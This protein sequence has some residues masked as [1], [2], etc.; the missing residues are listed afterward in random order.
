MQQGNQG[1]SALRERE[2]GSLLTVPALFVVGSLVLSVVTVVADELLSTLLPEAILFR[3]DSDSARSILSSIASSAITLTGLVFSV[4]M[5]VLQLTGAQYSPRSMGALLTD[6]NSKYTL[7][8]FVGTFTYSLAV[9][10]TIDP[11]GAEFDRG[12]SVAVA[13]LF[14]LVT[15]AFFIQYVNHVARQIRPASIIGRVAEAAEAAIDAH[16]PD[17]A[18]PV[19]PMLPTGEPQRVVPAPRAGVVKGIEVDAIVRWATKEDVVVQVVPAVGEFVPEGGPL[20]LVWGST[21]DGEALMGHVAL[22][23]E[24]S[25]KGDPSYG[26]RQLVD[27]A[28]RALSP[29]TNDPT[30]AVQ[31]VDHLHNLLRRLVARELPRG[32]HVDDEGRVRVIVATPDWQELLDLAV[33]EVAHYGEDSLQVRQRLGVMLRDLLSVAPPA[34]ASSIVA[35]LGEVERLPA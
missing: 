28:E 34:R 26:I 35:K 8:V 7:G 27:I 19:A 20:A 12:I 24:R 14:A 21:D 29:G 11:D 4:T 18:P 22:G 1:V 9:L 2:Q 30:T 15:V 5:L 16:L 25:L 6:R 33:D 17:E 10:R 3:G 23:E 32:V 13:V 31:A